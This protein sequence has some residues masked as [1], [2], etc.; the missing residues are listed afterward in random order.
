MHK[1]LLA[2]MQPLD[3]GWCVELRNGLIQPFP[4]QAGA[5]PCSEQLRDDAGLAVVQPAGNCLQ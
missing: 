1:Q 4:N 3:A 5:G 2:T